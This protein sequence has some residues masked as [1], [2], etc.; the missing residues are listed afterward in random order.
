MPVN[1]PKAITFGNG[2]FV[3]VGLA[4]TI[5]TSVDGVTWETRLPANHNASLYGVTYGNAK[6]VAVGEGGSIMVANESDLNTWPLVNTSTDVRLQG[7]A[8]DPNAGFMAVGN[9]Y[10]KSVDGQT[11][12]RIDSENGKGQWNGNGIAHGYDTWVRAGGF[13]FSSYDQDG[14][15]WDTDAGIATFNA[16]TFGNSSF[17]AV[18]G[19]T[20]ARSLPLSL[21]TVVKPGT[22][23][24]T[25]TGP[26]AFSGSL[27]GV[28]CGSTCS[29]F[30]LPNL[31][32]TLTA[33]A[34]T[35]SY[36]AGWA[37]WTGCGT[38]SGCAITMPATGEATVT[39][40]FE[41][42]G[43]LN[44]PVRLVSTGQ[45]YDTLQQAYDVAINGDT[46]KVQKVEPY[47]TGSLIADR[48]IAVILTGGY[49]YTYTSNAG[50]MTTL[51]GSVQTLLGA[52]TVGNFAITN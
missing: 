41:S 30:Y 17:V 19:R 2:M 52:V 27:S 31:P 6:F 25:V 4:S 12:T 15:T 36:F 7:V 29:Y 44:K 10:Y 21:L 48:N 14:F 39:A 8:F 20:I 26:A 22:G 9:V 37:E 32:V 46:I 49:N 5:A 16:I 11:W 24:G 38:N 34:D 3:V 23:T 28:S 33:V 13:L 43:C 42:L 1:Y 45:G 47:L 50:Y 51:K 35:C 40:A 18:G